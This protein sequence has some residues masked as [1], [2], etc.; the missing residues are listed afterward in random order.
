MTTLALVGKGR[1]GKNYISSIR[2]LSSCKLPENFIKT[3]DYK[4]LLS[5]KGIDGVIIATPAF[6]HFQIA[7]EFLEKGF[8]VLIEKPMTTNYK[9]ALRLSKISNKHKN[10][11]M[12]GHV[13]LYNPA[14]LEVKNLLNSIGKIKYISSEGMDDG[15]IRQDISVLWDWAPHDI[16]MSID[17]LGGLPVNVCGYGSK[18]S[19]SNRKFY[20]SCYLKLKF[21][22][23]IFVFIKVSWSSPVKKRN[24]IIVGEK[25]TIIF[26]D[27]V[28]RKIRLV[29]NLGKDVGTSFPSFSKI[30]PLSMEISNF[31]DQIKN[32]DKINNSSLKIGMDVIKVL[33]ACEKSIKLDGRNIKLNRF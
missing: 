3:T 21:T 32:K 5:S 10:I 20:D 9:D 33:E 14:F 25:G 22:K 11:V 17:L 13:Y 27:T 23:D 4:E 7:K 6:T 24:T 26:D 1:W 8:N 2:K 16:S 30:T 19:N 12:V 31:V 29:K 28:E 15:P 18:E